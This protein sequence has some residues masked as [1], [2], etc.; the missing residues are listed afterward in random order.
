[1]HSD[2]V[3]HDIGNLKALSEGKEVFQQ[4]WKLFSQIR[5]LAKFKPQIVSISLKCLFSASLLLTKACLLRSPKLSHKEREGET[6]WHPNLSL[7]NWQSVLGLPENHLK[8]QM[9]LQIGVR[10]GTGKQL[11]VILSSVMLQNPG[12]QQPNSKACV[13]LLAWF[14][15]LFVWPTA[16]QEASHEPGHCSPSVLYHLQKPSTE[17][18][19][20]CPQS[21]TLSCS[22][23]TRHK[24]EQL[25][26][27]VSA[28]L[29]QSGLQ[30]A[31]S[32]ICF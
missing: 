15:G 7:W 30:P 11:D 4:L 9:K 20:A 2:F 1:M 22:L 27:A 25:P 3:C 12:D 8:N 18:H 19:Y 23:F 28:Q 31:N 16:A 17:T 10:A 24:K 5:P 13:Q 29:H 32:E 21:L 6:S 26:G 14:T